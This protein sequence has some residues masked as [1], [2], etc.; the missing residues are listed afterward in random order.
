[1][2][3]DRCDKKQ[4]QTDPGGYSDEW[5]ANTG[6]ESKRSRGF[7]KAE[8]CQPRLRHAYFGH[9]DEDLLVTNEIERGRKQVSG[10]SQDRNNDVR[11]KHGVL[12]AISQCPR[13]SE[14]VSFARSRRA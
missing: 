4:D 13:F 12:M 7:E 1:M 6:Q 11:N 10:G 14:N 9:V 2:C 8:C 3:N 5:N